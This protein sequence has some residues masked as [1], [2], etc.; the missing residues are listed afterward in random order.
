M[1]LE[2]IIIVSGG[3]VLGLAGAVYARWS[4]KCLERE[5]PRQ[6]TAE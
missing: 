4:R 1:T 3:L 5:N 6:K 2:T